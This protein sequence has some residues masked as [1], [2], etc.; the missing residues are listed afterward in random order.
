MERFN[1]D[2]QTSRNQRHSNV[3]KNVLSIVC[4]DDEKLMIDMINCCIRDAFPDVIIRQAENGNEALTSCLEQPPDVLITNVNMP[5]MTGIQLIKELRRAKL[6]IPTL[7]TS[8]NCTYERLQREGIQL[9]QRIRFIYKPFSA[10][11]IIAEIK[12]LVKS[13]KDM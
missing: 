6:E 3:K 2:S 5:G 12:D 10:E 11:Q 1:R 9:N 7:I 8:G 13:L 4:A